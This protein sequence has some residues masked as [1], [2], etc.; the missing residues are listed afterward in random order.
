MQFFITC[1]PGVESVLK[2][3]VE[4]LGGQDILTSDRSVECSWPD[5]LLAELNISIR[6]GNRIYCVLAEKSGTTFD[7]LFDLTLSVDWGKYIPVDAPITV[8]A[9]SVRSGLD[10]VPAIQKTVK[11]AIVT[12]I[13]G[14]RETFLREDTSIPAIHIFVLVRENQIKILLDTSGE[15]LHKRGYR[16]ETL[17]API[18]E[19]L[20]AALVILS[21]WRYRESFVDPF[22]GSGTIVIEAAMIARNIMP[23]M[24]R[25][26]AFENFA[27]YPRN[28]LEEAKK[29]GEMKIMRDKTFTITGSD[30]DPEAVEIAKNNA[31]RAGVSDTV[32]FTVRDFKEYLGN[33]EE[34][35][36]KNWVFMKNEN[37][38]ESYGSGTMSEE[39]KFWMK[40]QSFSGVLVSNPPYGLRLQDYDLDLLYRDIAKIFSENPSLSGGIITSYDYGKLI[41]RDDWKNRKLY[42]G[43]ELCYFFSKK[44]PK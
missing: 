32:T 38:N 20:A 42:N 40:N 44:P 27:W 29:K 10:S 8:D 6:T 24:H 14:D 30:T 18:K 23:G 25:N 35:F 39:A 3:E 43:N 1:T 2:H 7:S 34:L 33:N 4:W 22:C 5:S 9:L 12:K 21:G 15:P 17:E 16:T 41:R 26:F 28:H 36:K 37:R 13:T 31:M 19:T 11:K